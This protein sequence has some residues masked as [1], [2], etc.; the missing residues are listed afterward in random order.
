MLVYINL[1]DDN[2]AIAE[3]NNNSILVQRILI[4]AISFQNPKLKCKLQ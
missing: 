4:H 3:N 2:T 1:V